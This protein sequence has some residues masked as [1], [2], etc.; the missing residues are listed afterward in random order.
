MPTLV[1][2][3]SFAKKAHPKLDP[4][5]AALVELDDAVFAPVDPASPQATPPA[6]GREFTP[7]RARR[8]VERRTGPLAFLTGPRPREGKSEREE[9]LESASFSFVSVFVTAKSADALDRIA[10][11]VG[12]FQWQSRAGRIGTA[13]VN[14]AQLYLLEQDDEVEA[15]EWTGGAKP[16]GLRELRRGVSPRAAVG[17]DAKDAELDGSGVVVGIVDIE[18]L[19]IYHPDFTNERGTPRVLAL[20]DQTASRV[21][22]ELGARPKGYGYGVEYDRADLWA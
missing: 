10:L 4:R 14:L 16:L 22:G 3:L 6:G 12:F 9:R 8:K 17:L 15:V 7:E 21:E 20:W 1:S 2:P 18:G 11:E 5:L 13:Q 19:D